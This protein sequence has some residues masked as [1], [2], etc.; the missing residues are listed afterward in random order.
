MDEMVGQQAVLEKLDIAMTAAKKRGEPLEHILLDGPPGLGKTTIAHV[1]ARE[2]TGKAPRITSGPSLGKQADL[3]ALLTN[4]EAGDVLFIDEIHRLPKIVEEFL[5][6]AMEDFRVD[7]TIEGG[8]SGRVVN[9]ALRRFTLIGATTRA[10]LLSGAL[11][12]RFGHGLHLDFYSTDDLTT[13]LHRSA[14]K[15]EFRGETGALETIAKRSRGTPR[16]ANRLLRRVR[17]YAQVRGEGKLN[18][19][20]VHEGLEIQQV[21][22]L[23]LDELDRAFLTALI[24]TYK[25]GPAGI[26]A[27][28]ATMGQERDT[29]EDM[30]EPYLLQIGFIIRTRQGRQATREAYDHLH[31]PFVE[32]SHRQVA[33]AARAMTK[34][35][36]ESTLFELK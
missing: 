36:D 10:G 6:P 20:A 25:G 15:L 34:P 14:S 26:E 18:E 8:L 19:R 21:D 22:G 5:Y 11:R 9:F 29:L 1:I 13:I 32:P 2:M 16:V 24:K 12:D 3:M 30:V 4:L 17:D 35:S 27:L 31:L 23:G 28:A 33:G 7:F